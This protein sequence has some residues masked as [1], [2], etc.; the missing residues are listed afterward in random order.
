VPSAAI[1]VTTLYTCS[2]TGDLNGDG[3][4]DL[5]LCRIAVAASEP[6]DSI[7]YL[8]QPDGSFSEGGCR[9]TSSSSEGPRSA[10]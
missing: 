5:L 8:Q 6:A 3:L 1:N 9:W 7:L 10:T 4:D 2:R